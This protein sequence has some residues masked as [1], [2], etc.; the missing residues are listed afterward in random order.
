MYAVQNLHDDAVRCF[1]RSIDLS[2]SYGAH[3]GLAESYRASGQ[4]ELWKP[5]LLRFLDV[6]SFG[7]EHGW[8]HQRIANDHI[9]RE[10]W[11]AAEP[12]A[13]A[14]AQT[15]SQ[16]GL[17]LA[18]EVCEALG[19]WD[20]SEKW[21]REVAMSYRSGAGLEWYYWCRRTGRGDLATARKLAESVMTPAWLKSNP[22]R[23]MI[24]FVDCLLE[25]KPQDALAHGK[26][27]I[28]N[29]KQ[30]DADNRVY[31]RMH[32]AMAAAEAKDIDLRHAMIGE[33]RELLTKEAEALA[34]IDASYNEVIS[35]ICKLADGQPEVETEESAA[36]FTP[37]SIAELRT[38]L[39]AWPV[40]ERRNY[41]YLAGRALELR[42]EVDAADSF[43]RIIIGEAPFNKHCRNLA[44]YRLA[45]RH[46]TSRP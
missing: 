8:I 16:W 1:E 45:K 27:G 42:G 31:F 2:P 23:D 10:E 36:G 20:E 46:G 14:A 40:N 12:H 9:A 29:A 24:L 34:A 28:E 26:A 33:I 18:A 22:Q 19:R 38:R 41:L 4:S 44:G 15:W 3:V 7:L 30:L 21:T 35:F 13:M 17:G 6:S 32:Q 25:G 43:Y 5:T 11:E 37:E 39:E